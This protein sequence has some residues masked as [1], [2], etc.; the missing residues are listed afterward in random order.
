M[1]EIKENGNTNSFH[2]RDLYDGDYAPCP[3][4]ALYEN[5]PSKKKK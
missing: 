3:Q 2:N 1:K 5:K 4:N